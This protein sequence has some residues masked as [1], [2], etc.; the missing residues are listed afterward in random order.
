MH[1]TPTRWSVL[2]WPTSAQK[3]EKGESGER[4]TR[5]HAHN[6]P[7]HPAWQPH[8]HN[9]GVVAMAWRLGQGQQACEELGEAANPTLNL[10]GEPCICMLCISTCDTALLYCCLL[11][12]PAAAAAAAMHDRGITAR[13]PARRRR[14][15]QTTNTVA[16]ACADVA[17]AKRYTDKHPRSE[18]ST[19]ARGAEEIPQT[20]F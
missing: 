11:P 4:S 16:D 6:P 7:P 15:Q 20:M 14:R 17:G 13:Q 1:I 3:R 5:I 2:G 19:A 12:P 10:I 18:T 8:R 9:D